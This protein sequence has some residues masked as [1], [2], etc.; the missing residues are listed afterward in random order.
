MTDF[1]RPFS[2]SSETARRE[3]NA[4]D[5]SL[6]DSTVQVSGAADR[7]DTPW[8]RAAILTPSVETFMNT[9]LLGAPDF[10]S[11]RSFMV[12]PSRAVLM[13]FSADPYRG[14]SLNAFSGSAVNFLATTTFGQRT[15]AL[16]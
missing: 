15:A 9:T 4:D 2:G 16:R 11:L 6:I 3:P 5:Q 14:M 12:K 1:I 13:S 7:L 8:M 10:V